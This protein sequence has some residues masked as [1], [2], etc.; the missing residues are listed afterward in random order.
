MVFR[1]RTFSDSG[2]RATPRSERLRLKDEDCFS[3]L[4]S[5]MNDDFDFEKNLALF[6][7][8]TVFSAI[9]QVRLIF[10]S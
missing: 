4:V 2:A 8:M 1:S 6:D 3:P 7:K 5:S 10:L 9:D